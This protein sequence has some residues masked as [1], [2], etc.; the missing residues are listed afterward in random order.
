MKNL[1]FSFLLFLCLGITLVSCKK[2][3]AEPSVINADDFSAALPSNMANGTVVGTVSAT[4][5]G[6]TLTYS[7]ASQGITGALAINATTGQ[8]TVASA[9]AIYAFVCV[10]NRPASFTVT[11][12]INNGTTTKN[13]TLTIAL[14]SI[15]CT[16]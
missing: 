9:S 3:E 10:P 7:L 6:G 16:A 5:N 4:T 1:S 15:L 2:N 12:T 11:I 13:I 8:I 14:G